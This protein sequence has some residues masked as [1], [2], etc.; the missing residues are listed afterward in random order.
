MIVE[1]QLELLEGEDLTSPESPVKPADEV[2]AT[3][4]GGAEVTLEDKGLIE[5]AKAMGIFE[6]D[7]NSPEAMDHDANL[8]EFIDEK[9]LGSIANELQDSFERDKQS[10]D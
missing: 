4:D 1:K 3:P 10:R 9:E 8:V 6:E 7:E 2:I 5:E